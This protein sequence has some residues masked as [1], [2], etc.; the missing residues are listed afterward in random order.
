MGNMSRCKNN[1]VY[2]A[3]KYAVCPFCGTIDAGRSGAGAAS[4]QSLG[5][6]QEWRPDEIE[7]GAA[8]PRQIQAKGGSK[9]IYQETREGRRPVY[10]WLV[11]VEGPGQG[12][13]FAVFA[14]L[15]KIGREHGE[16][17]L[18]FGDLGIG[19]DEHAR[20]LVDQKTLRFA[21]QHGNGKNL[22]YVNDEA[23]FATHRELQ[24]YDRVRIS[25]TTLAFVPFCSE[26]FSWPSTLK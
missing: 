8:K 20:L 4:R 15:N 9:T 5:G 26:R 18:D 13:S 17:T 24:G 3:D 21:L 16:V 25:E 10:G 6:T 7:M 23:L 2:D 11:I 1:H 22:T 14:G 19:G 12:A